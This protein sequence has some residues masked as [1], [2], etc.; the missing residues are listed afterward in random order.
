MKGETAMGRGGE[1]AKRRVPASP[2][3]L[4]PSPSRPLAVSPSLLPPAGTRKN[5][6]DPRAA[7]GL[8]NSRVR[9]SESATPET[10]L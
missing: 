9:E 8:E 10:S 4:A 5:A 7:A 6:I 2:R 1:T 3:R